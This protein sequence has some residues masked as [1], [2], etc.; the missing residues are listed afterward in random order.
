MLSPL[1]TLNNLQQGADGVYAQKKRQSFNYSDGEA[2]EQ[3][4]YEIL[5]TANDL[6][7]DSAELE[8]SI[9][10]WPTEYHLSSTRANL[11]RALDLSNAKQVLELGCGCGAISRYLGEQ[12][13]MQ[14]DSVEGSPTRA[15]LAALRCQDLDN[16]TVSC[17]NFNQMQFPESHYD[18]VLLVGVTEYAGR[19][20]EK[21][22]DQQALQDLLAMAKKAIKPD[23]VVLIAIENRFGLKYLMGACEDHY[24]LPDIGLNDYPNST[25]IRT[26]SKDEWQQQIANAGFAD[27]KFL[28]PFPDY[29][30][31]T[32][33]VTDLDQSNSQLE[34]ALASISSR[35]YLTSFNLGQREAAL[36]K[37]MQQAN[38]LET[39]ANS[40]M[41]LI[42]NSASVIQKMVP[43][44]LVYFK[45]TSFS[46][47]QGASNPEAAAE[48]PIEQN[49]RAEVQHL[50][51]KLDQLSL[52][53]W[54]KLRNA[55]LKLIGKGS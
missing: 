17:G 24:A 39:F 48:S 37:V 30:I 15:G 18:L 55:I 12:P 43:Q 19:F 29:K 52:S 53:R 22:T 6:R 27:Y 51:S 42:G 4:L 7:S 26:Y 33:V 25:G 45:Q 23:G 11:L 3:R 44:S 28:Y 38:S 46:Y 20:S 5:S 41:M 47:L 9:C 49:L 35:D 32:L 21:E 10:D 8:I 1:I 13:D 54:W 36:W 31:P 14:I 2:T 50:Q 40:F 34:P 16:V